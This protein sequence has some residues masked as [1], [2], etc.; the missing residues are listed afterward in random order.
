MSKITNSKAQSSESSSSD[1]EQGKSDNN[2]SY[3]QHQ[4]LF[5]TMYIA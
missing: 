3:S 4:G 2:L 5:I 1:S